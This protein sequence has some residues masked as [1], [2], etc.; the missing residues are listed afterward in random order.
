ML[1]VMLGS[2][3]VIPTVTR[4]AFIV[5]ILN[6]WP[7]KYIVFIVHASKSLAQPALHA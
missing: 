5:I 3:H 6:I 2:Y 7:E 4:V 1:R